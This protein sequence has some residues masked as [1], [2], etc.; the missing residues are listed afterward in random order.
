MEFLPRPPPSSLRTAFRLTLQDSTSLGD[1]FPFPLVVDDARGD[2][3]RSVLD[4][5]PAFTAYKYRLH[6]I[7]TEAFAIIMRTIDLDSPQDGNLLHV[8][9][10]H[11]D[12]QAQQISPAENSTLCESSLRSLADVSFLPVLFSI[13][14]LCNGIFYYLVPCL[15]SSECIYA[16]ESN[17]CVPVQT[18]LL[19][20]PRVS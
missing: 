3:T 13:F 16:L 14:T 10:N 9:L 2:R 15:H 17:S 12:A 4:G 18:A 7:K 5:L 6:R 19:F 20:S 1:G 11:F 8:L